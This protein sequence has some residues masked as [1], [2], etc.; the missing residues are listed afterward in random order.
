M[1]WRERNIGNV[2]ATQNNLDLVALYLRIFMFS[3]PNIKPK[4]K[5]FYGLEFGKDFIRYKKHDS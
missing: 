2:H 1:L 4:P 3:N 5:I